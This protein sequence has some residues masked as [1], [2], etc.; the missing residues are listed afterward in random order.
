[1][2]LQIKNITLAT[3]L[4]A[5]LNVLA[6]TNQSIDMYQFQTKQQSQPTKKT[7][8]KSSN[9]NLC[10]SYS[11]LYQLQNKKVKDLSKLIQE[12]KTQTNSNLSFSYR[13][14]NEKLNKTITNI[15]NECENKYFKKSKIEQACKDNANLHICHTENQTQITQPSTKTQKQQT[16]Y[17]IKPLKIEISKIPEISKQS[18]QKQYESQANQSELNYYQKLETIYQREL[19]DNTQSIEKLSKY[20]TTHSHKDSYTCLR[21]FE[22]TIN[23]SVENNKTNNS[24][25]TK[26]LFKT[27][28]QK[29][30]NCTDKELRASVIEKYCEISNSQICKTLQNPKYV[31]KPTSIINSSRIKIYSLKAL[32]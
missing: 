19:L 5:S 15:H 20:Y 21:N 32:N 28:N 1:M 4:T 22:T 26:I 27:Y 7:H 24:E 12:N 23:Q 29:N 2:K 9:L 18:Q 17:K 14:S 13:L 3:L 16:Y 31:N 11:D 30:K 25:K 6:V 8:I 10:K